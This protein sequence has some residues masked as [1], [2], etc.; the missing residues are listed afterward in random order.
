M[1]RVMQINLRDELKKIIPNKTPDRKVNKTTAHILEPQQHYLPKS[2]TKVSIRR[3]L[4]KE[5]VKA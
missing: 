4:R 1:S 5:P 2:A 3:P